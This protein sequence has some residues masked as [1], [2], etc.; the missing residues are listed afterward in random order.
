[1]TP[2]AHQVHVSRAIDAFGGRGTV[3][4]RRRHTLHDSVA[5][6]RVEDLEVAGAVSQGEEQLTLHRPGSARLRGLLAA[7]VVLTIGAD[8]Y[9]VASDVEAVG[10]ILSAVPLVTPVVTALA[11]GEAAA[12]PDR[13]YKLRRVHASRI[14]SSSDGRVVRVAG[15]DYVVAA[16]GAAIVPRE[17]DAIVVEDG[18]LVEIATV[19]TWGPS[20]PPAG[21]VLRRTTP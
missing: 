10:E 13:A 4:L 19:E 9:E 1:M 17:G 3:S 6:T 12:V 11:G 20:D 14:E 21:W 8:S 18:D 5:G 16:M 7:G 15:G 2:L